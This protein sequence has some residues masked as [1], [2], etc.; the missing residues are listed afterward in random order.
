[1]WDS[2]GKIRNHFLHFFKKHA[3]KTFSSPVP[4]RSKAHWY[5]MIKH[6]REYL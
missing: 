4:M 3:Q 1:M 5:E 2:N 6:T